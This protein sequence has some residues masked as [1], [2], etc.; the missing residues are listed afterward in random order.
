MQKKNYLEKNNV[1]KLK[2]DALLKK[3]QK[4]NT[5]SPSKNDSSY[6]S[7]KVYLKPVHTIVC[8]IIVYTKLV[9]LI[10]YYTI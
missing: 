2:K 3:K 7:G 9:L 4:Q 6:H 1:N 8:T 10:V 5:F